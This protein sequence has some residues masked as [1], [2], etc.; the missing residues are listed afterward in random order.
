MAK[1]S[2]NCPTR[3]EVYYDTQDPR[4]KGWAYR[5]YFSRDSDRAREES[6]PHTSR[7]RDV[8]LATLARQARK[9]VGCPRSRT[10]VVKHD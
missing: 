3:I 9:A 6:G 5:A 1:K 2:A 4:N 10:M 7:R 8:K